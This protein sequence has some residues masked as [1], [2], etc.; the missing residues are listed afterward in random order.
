MRHFLFLHHCLALCALGILKKAYIKVQRTRLCGDIFMRFFLCL[1][2]LSFVSAKGG[3]DFQSKIQKKIIIFGA[4]YVGTVSGACLAKCGHKITF[5]DPDKNKIEMLNRKKSPV[6]EPLLEALI[7]Q[8]V[9]HQL[10]EAK[11][12]LG[13]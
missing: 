3:C 12:E 10:I 11:C 7:C 5:I 4:G 8:G 2:L 13:Q 6:S 1:F 9:E